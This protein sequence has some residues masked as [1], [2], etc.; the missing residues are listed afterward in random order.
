[1][2]R[3][4][5]Q[6]RCHRARP[7]DTGA[8]RKA[9]ASVLLLGTMLVPPC[10][11]PR[12]ASE[13][14]VE[15]RGSGLRPNNQRCFTDMGSGGW[16]CARR[17]NSR[18]NNGQRRARIGRNNY[19]WQAHLKRTDVTHNVKVTGRRRRSGRMTS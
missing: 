8:L 16:T 18:A 9:G 1:M 14:Q 19:C 7:C 3:F 4:V 2:G 15:A 17:R 5:M 11:C 12:A 6:G 10:Q 13:R